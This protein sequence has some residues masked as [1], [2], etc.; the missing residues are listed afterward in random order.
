ML[1]LLLATAMALAPAAHAAKRDAVCATLKRGKK[2]PYVVIF[3]A[4]P[5]EARPIVAAMT[6]ESQVEIAGRP[7]Y[8]GR[9]GRV[10]VIVGLVGIGLVNA[11]NTTRAVLDQFRVAAILFSG[12]AGSTSRIGEVVV[13]DDWVEHSVAGAFSR[14]HAPHGGRPPRAGRARRHARELYAGAARQPIT[15]TERC[16]GFQP[17]FIIGGHGSSSDPYTACVPCPPGQA[18]VLG[19]TL[20]PPRRGDR[21]RDAAVTTASAAPGPRSPTS[22]TWRPPPS[23]ASPPSSTSRSSASAACP[24]GPAI[25]SRE[26]VPQQFFDYY[27]I[28]ADNAA[29]VTRSV[30][31]QL[32]ALTKSKPGR[33]ACKALAKGQVGQ[34]RGAAQPLALSTIR[35]RTSTAASA[36]SRPSARCA[37]A[38]AWAS[39]TA[40]SQ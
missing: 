19:C 3:S 20:P 9:I 37:R 2:A 38:D 34:G 39:A 5:A 29:I 23:R 1:P 11:E 10:R 22:S 6:Y 35:I 14:Q 17:Q 4:F 24:T 21:R 25:R 31:A 15:P 13:P 33:K 7:F 27:V 16:L 18:S 28:S 12:V 40:R 32:D 30:V 36:R 26:R 8:L